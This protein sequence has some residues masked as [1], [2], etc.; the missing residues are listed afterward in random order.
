MQ[1][2]SILSLTIIVFSWPLVTGLLA[3]KLGRKFWFWFFA[4]VPLPFIAVAILLF[5]PHKLKRSGLR[6]VEREN[7]VNHL[8]SNEHEKNIIGSEA[9]YSATA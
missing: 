4:G 7:T 8:F 3:R 9:P 5:I 1:I 6:P 2:L